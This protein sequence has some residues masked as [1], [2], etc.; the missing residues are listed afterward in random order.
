M[1]AFLLLFLATTTIVANGQTTRNGDF[2]LDET[3]KVTE[4]GTIDLRSSDAKVFITGSS[5]KDLHLKVDRQVDVK[6]FVTGDRE[7]SMEVEEVN[8]GLKISERQHSSTVGIV[9][10]YYEKY[11][12]E[13]EAPSGMSLRVRG[14]DG[15]Y[16]IKSMNGS[17]ELDLDDA[18]VELVGCKGDNFSI[19]LDDGDIKIDEARGTLELSA[20]DADVEIRNAKFTSIRAEI[21]DGDFI[22]QTTLADDGDYYIDSQDGLISFAVAGG[23]GRFD[24]RHDDA[25]IRTDPVFNQVEDSEQRSRFTLGSGNAKVDIRAD[26]ARVRLTKL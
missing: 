23:G 19:R 3:Y 15:D 20:D 11:T 16:L 14:D 1:K 13:I 8:G 4:T 7:F 21:D 17:M 22:V 10:Y 25:S 5:R 12:I 26:D 2:K 6:G 24:I 9:G 18:D